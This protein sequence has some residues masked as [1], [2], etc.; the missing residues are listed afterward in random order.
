MTQ[1]LA[2]RAPE[3]P[4]RFAAKQGPYLAFIWAYSQINRRAPAEADV[5]RCFKV[6][7]PAVHQMVK[8]LD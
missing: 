6:T 7:A 3:L 2:Q 4:A 1:L 8:T 5:E